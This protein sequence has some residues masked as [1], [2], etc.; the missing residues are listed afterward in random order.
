MCYLAGQADDRPPAAVRRR[1]AGGGRWAVVR[2]CRSARVRPTLPGG[3]VPRPSG[4]T[5]SAGAGTPRAVILR[6]ILMYRPLAVHVDGE[7][8]LT[9]WGIRFI[10]TGNIPPSE[11]SAAGVLN[12]G[13]LG[14]SLRS[15]G[16]RL[17]LNIFH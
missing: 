14:K 15:D 5:R 2:W 11:L 7:I 3:N 16:M 1:T 6:L 10:L 8:G 4:A 9:I 17:V 13:G 12:Y